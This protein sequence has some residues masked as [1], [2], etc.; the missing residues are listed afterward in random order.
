MSNH[1][2]N[3]EIALQLTLKAMDT[4]YILKDADNTSIAET[5]QRNAQAVC[6]FYRV[7]RKMQVD[8]TLKKY[9][10]LC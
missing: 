6:D 2:S 10:N 1:M 7:I 3:D 8:D 9:D 4:G 5:N